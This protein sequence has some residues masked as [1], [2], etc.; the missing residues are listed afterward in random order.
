MVNIFDFFSIAVTFIVVYFAAKLGGQAA[1]NEF[2]EQLIKDIKSDKT[3]KATNTARDILNI[4]K[5]EIVE[6]LKKEDH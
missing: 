3:F 1:L 5:K 2:K 4:F 6:E